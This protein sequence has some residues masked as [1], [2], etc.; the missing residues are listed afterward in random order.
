MA[1]VSEKPQF[2]R[3]TSDVVNFLAD[4]KNDLGL[5]IKF[6][7]ESEVTPKFK[8]K[9]VTAEVAQQ[10]DNM[11]ASVPG[12]AFASAE[13]AEGKLFTGEY[14]NTGLMLSGPNGRPGRLEEQTA[15]IAAATAAELQAVARLNS[16]TWNVIRRE[17][18]N[19][20]LDQAIANYP[21]DYMPKLYNRSNG[22]TEATNREKLLKEFM[23][24]NFDEQRE[25]SLR[26]GVLVSVPNNRQRMGSAI[27]RGHRAIAAELKARGL[28]VEVT[29][30]GRENVARQD[31]SRG[32]VEKVNAVQTSRPRRVRDGM[33]I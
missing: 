13:R 15:Q 30:Q 29:L 26:N 33:S 4:T 24:L 23:N 21:Q 3:R 8:V 14:G 9:P 25:K 19:L 1:S 2:D 10:L 12:A 27:M 31:E 22:A 11:G 16:K 20:R 28:T 17:E 6:L 7:D 18:A 32:F 5:K